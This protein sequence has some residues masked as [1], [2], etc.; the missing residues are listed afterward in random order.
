MLKAIQLPASTYYAWFHDRSKP[1]RNRRSG[2]QLSSKE[3]NAIIALLC[4]AET[5]DYSIYHLF[6][7]HFNQGL[8]VGSLSTFYRIARSM[9]MVGDR[10]PQATHPK[11]EAPI[12]LATRPDQVWCWDITRIPGPV[13]GLD[14]FL[15][16][17]I[18]LY[19]RFVVGWMLA[20]H[21]NARLA[22]HFLRESLRKI[23]GERDL[24]YL[25]NHSD[26]GAAMMALQT[27]QV[28]EDAGIRRSYSRPR[29]SDDNPFVESYFKTVKYH[30]NYPGF[31]HSKAEA[32]A[33]LQT[34]VDVYHH[35]PHSG[36]RGYT[37]LQAYT[38][39]W[40]QVWDLR[41][42]AL[43]DYVQ[44]HPTRFRKPPQALPLQNLVSI[45]VSKSKIQN[46]SEK[47]TPQVY[48]PT[49]EAPVSDSWHL[50]PSRL[51]ETPHPS[52]SLH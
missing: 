44:K 35:T 12:L 13:A 38:N 20:E 45:N 17:L 49:T 39:A 3:R 46:I 36:L 18:D 25:T 43:D 19:S 10:R 52:G 42:Q 14:Y 21:E 30:A 47:R 7:H 5:V 22:A 26:R 27:Q 28:L 24:V 41:Q 48:V 31:F 50:W 8:Y 6:F 1:G 33:W 9:A 32:E 29:V 15:F 40:Q 11:R 51:S 23:Q 34:F 37:P 16:V 4:D 2:N